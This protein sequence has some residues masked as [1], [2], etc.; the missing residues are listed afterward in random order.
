MPT[1]SELGNELLPTEPSHEKTFWMTLVA[2]CDILAD[3]PAKLSPQTPDSH[4]L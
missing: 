1:M 3:Y 4:K 2:T